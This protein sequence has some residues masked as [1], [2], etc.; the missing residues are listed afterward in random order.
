[1][2][3]KVLVI[4]TDGGRA[5]VLL[6]E[7]RRGHAPNLSRLNR[8][9]QSEEHGTC[10]PTHPV[11]P[12]DGPTYKPTTGP[13][14]GRKFH[15][16]TCAGWSA[17]LSGVNNA[18]TR[19]ADNS[20][21]S[22]RHY[23]DQCR[24]KHPTFLRVAHRK[25]LRTL[26][27]GRPNVVGDH[28]KPDSEVGSERDSDVGILDQD[29]RDGMID[30]YQSVRVDRGGQPGDAK[31]TS[32]AVRKIKADEVDVAF[33]HLDALDQ[34]GHSRGWGSPDQVAA[35]K[36]ID[37]NVGRMLRAI[38]RSP[39]DWAVFLTSDHGGMLYSHGLNP[40]YDQCIPF[41]SNKHLVSPRS[42]GLVRQFDMA[43]TVLTYLGIRPP[44]GTDGVS[45]LPMGSAS[46]RRAFFRMLR[47]EFGS[48]MRRKE[49]WIAVLLA[50]ASASCHS[51]PAAKHCN[52]A[53]RAFPHIGRVVHHMKQARATYRGR[54]KFDFLADVDNLLSFS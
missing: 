22:I 50:R 52:A 11:R 53:S 39:H 49:E 48:S 21:T 25:G 35:V 16:V 40:V 26:A 46:S 45:L 18:K 2:V 30:V 37:K 24:T 7:I 15:W 43:P 10:G 41:F 29:A 28:R 36:S 23:W 1:M 27:V 32:L 8:F 5:D 9:G 12:Q 33:V 14:A 17:M 47:A 19:V 4:G 38:D 42:G 51:A 31:N 20:T 54:G 13:D 34:A 3:R 6:G 44:R